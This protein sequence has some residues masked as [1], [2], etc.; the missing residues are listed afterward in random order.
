MGQ[1]SRACIRLPE[2]AASERAGP[3]WWHR[4]EQPG[5]LAKA[6]ALV[7]EFV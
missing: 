1:V 5:V 3:G 4:A 6:T 7:K 2:R